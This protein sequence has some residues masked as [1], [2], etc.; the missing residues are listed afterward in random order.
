MYQSKSTHLLDVHALPE[1]LY[2]AVPRDELQQHQ[3]VALHV[4]LLVHP[5]R[6]RVLAFVSPK[7]KNK[8][9]TVIK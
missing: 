6:V 9:Y 1:A 7:K 2:G 3:S 4:A 8:K 5:Q